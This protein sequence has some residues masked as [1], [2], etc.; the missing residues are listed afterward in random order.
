M[1]RFLC[2]LFMS[3]LLTAPLY[4]QTPLA[5]ALPLLQKQNRTAAENQ[6]I[7][8]LF[9]T[10]KDPDT[11]FAA[12]ASLVKTPPAKVQE[13]ALFNIVLRAGDGLKQ[14]F[15]AVIITAMGSRHDELISVLQPALAGQDTVLR[16][17]AAGAYGLLRPQDK[18][19]TDDV[20]RLYAFDPAFAQ[21][22][23]NSLTDSPSQLLTYLKQASAAPAAST[24]AA[25][26]AWLG[27][28]H[29]AA[30]AKQLLKRAGKETDPAV[31]TQI[32]TA[33]AKNQP[34]T[35]TQT[36]GGLKKNYKTPKIFFTKRRKKR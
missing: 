21:R 35:L 31:T 11:V 3:A 14:T 2:A 34:Y 32:A 28:Q 8:Q 15:A 6:Q 25:A 17:Y 20:V 33:L 1:Q 5:Q 13:P 16:A 7:L 24:R 12:G 36:A 27:D 29:T 10:A 9:R 26:A 23:M 19:Y 22:A 18:T 4:A 30:C